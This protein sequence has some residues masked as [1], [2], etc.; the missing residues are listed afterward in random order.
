MRPGDH[1]LPDDFPDLTIPERTPDPPVPRAPDPA[2]PLSFSL[3]AQ[4]KPGVWPVGDEVL[5]PWEPDFA[6]PGVIDRIDGQRVL[7]QFDD[8]GVGWVQL[9]QVQPLKLTVGQLVF[10]RRQRSNFYLAC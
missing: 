4:R 10:S 3:D 5:A 2:R 7:I 9:K 1:G 8:G 6:Y